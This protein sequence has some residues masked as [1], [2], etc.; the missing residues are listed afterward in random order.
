MFG[1]SCVAG[2]ML[3]ASL[4]GFF[5]FAHF[6]TVNLICAALALYGLYNAVNDKEPERE[7]GA[8]VLGVKKIV[9]SALFVSLGCCFFVV[10]L[11]FTGMTTLVAIILPERFG[12]EEWQLALALMTI[13][14]F[15]FVCLA[16]LKRLVKKYG[17]L[18][19]IFTSFIVA[20]LAQIAL[21]FEI[22]YIHHALTVGLFMLSTIVLPLGMT[23]G[24]LLAPGIA[25]RYGKNAKGT[26]IGFLRTVFNVGQAVGPIYAVYF[27]DYDRFVQ[28]GAFFVTQSALMVVVI[29][30]MYY[31]WSFA[32]KHTQGP[33]VTD[34]AIIIEICG[35]ETRGRDVTV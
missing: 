34:E 11:Q 10:G 18:N 29:F 31:N 15:H 24:N 19:L 30:I 9:S 33:V 4:G 27:L 5:G 32:S 6:T 20:I 14:A 3:G 21:L 13:T 22:S 26:T 23:V 17:M 8:K 7:G 16:N 2:F 28:G 12:Y 25:D 1:M 35:I